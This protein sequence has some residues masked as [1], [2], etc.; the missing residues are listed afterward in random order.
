MAKEE[1]KEIAW[2]KYP[3]VIERSCG[4]SYDMNEKHA[5]HMLK[6]LKML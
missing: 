5:R 3:K 4:F 1:I 2:K 6:V